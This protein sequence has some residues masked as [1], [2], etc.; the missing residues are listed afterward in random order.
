M[1]SIKFYELSLN[2]HM[3]VRLLRARVHIKL[4][5][6]VHIKNKIHTQLLYPSYNTGKFLFQTSHINCIIS[7]TFYFGY[8]SCY[9]F[10]L[11]T[12]HLVSNIYV[13][14]LETIVSLGRLIL[15]LTLFLLVLEE[16]GPLPFCCLPYLVPIQNNT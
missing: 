3:I 4:F 7:A 6:Q 14:P 5:D 12:T 8:L 10:H 15:V 13:W 16:E 1:G 11:S 9:F 2:A